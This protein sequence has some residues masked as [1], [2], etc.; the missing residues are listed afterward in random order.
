MKIGQ[1]SGNT[2]WSPGTSTR[3]EAGAKTATAAE[4]GAAQVSIS[5]LSGQLH[6]I[7]SKLTQ[8]V[9]FD[10]ARVEEIKGAIRNGEFRVNPSKVADKLIDSVRELVGK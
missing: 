2:P 9:G 1:G 7:E 8:G 4:G 5:T 3:T 6:D 10:A